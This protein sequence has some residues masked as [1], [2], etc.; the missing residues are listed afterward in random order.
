MQGSG[1]ALVRIVASQWLA[2]IYAT[3]VMFFL[4]AFLARK[5]GPASLAIFLY[6]QAIA[7]LFA[8][9]QD[10]GFQTLVFREKVAQSGNPELSVH[11]L[12]SGYFSYVML[13]T[14]AG[15]AVVLL[16]GTAFKAAFLLAFVYLALRCFTNIISA[17][18]KGRGSFTREALWRIQVSTFLA[19]P[20]VLLIVWTPP[21]PEKVFLGFMIGQLLLMFTKIGRDFLS[22]PKWTFPSWPVWKTCLP[23]LLINGATMVYFKSDMIL[24]KHLQPDLNVVGYYGAA[25]QF[26]EGVILLATPVVHL[27]F[28]QMRLGWLDRDAFYRRLEAG[29]LL[30]SAVALLLVAAGV[31]FA[32]R[33]IVL[34]FGE[35]FSPASELLA[36]LLVSLIFLLPNFILTQGII[37]QNGEKY[38]AVAAVGCALFNVGLNLLLI[39]AYAAKGAALATVATEALL[40][41]LAGIWLVRRRRSGMAMQR[42]S[43]K[44]EE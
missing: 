5:L 1:F 31:I 42:V 43:G 25:F 34:V 33:I 35:A 29:L 9:F 27:L 30:A 16:S 6:V 21:S 19:V 37:A 15:S 13:V 8:I 28:R 44:G 39:P 22:R 26:L 24:L 20:V 23:F 38:Y 3:G 7:S 41:L 36:L 10:G 12:V 11:T 2:V 14:L 32:S 18:L 40:T 17:L 4:M